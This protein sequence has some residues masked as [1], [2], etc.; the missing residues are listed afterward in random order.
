MDRFSRILI[1]EYFSKICHEVPSSLKSDKNNGYF[2]KDQYIFWSYLARLFLEWEMLQTEIVKQIK[3]HILCSI[4]FFFK[5][6]NFKD[7][8]GKYGTAGPA[9]NGE[10]LRRMRF[11]CWIPKFTNTCSEYVILIDSPMQQLSY[12]H[13]LILR[14]TYIACLVYFEY[15]NFR[16]KYEREQ[17][18]STM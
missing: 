17:K 8:V 10:I 11:A 1:L 3:T 13:A 18:I 9:T 6:W 14:Y 7:N 2:N 4:T 15:W 16:T 5:S 12:E